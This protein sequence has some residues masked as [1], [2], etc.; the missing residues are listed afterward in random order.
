MERALQSFKYSNRLVQRT[1]TYTT[2]IDTTDDIDV[3]G[4]WAMTIT[5]LKFV[6]GGKDEDKLYSPKIQL[7]V[8]RQLTVTIYDYAM[9][10]ATFVWDIIW[11]Y[12]MI[13][14]WL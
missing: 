10:A 14:I 9:A 7:M 13:T 3:F 8:R 4:M 1:V 12:H 11:R 2:T 6:V 5:T